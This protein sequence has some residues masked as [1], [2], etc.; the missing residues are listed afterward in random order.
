MNAVGTM[1]L[2][3]FTGK[4][5]SVDEYIGVAQVAKRF[6]VTARTVVR[7]ISEGELPGS[8]RVTP[9]VKNSPFLIPVASVE[10]FAKKRPPETSDTN[11][12][13]TKN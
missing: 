12:N 3:N 13:E 5:M 7:W 2:N 9:G 11:G 8:F 4:G 10:A 6:N 1:T